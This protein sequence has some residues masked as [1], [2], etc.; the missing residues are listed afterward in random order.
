VAVLSIATERLS[1]EV[2]DPSAAPQV[3]DYLVRNRAFHRPWDPPRNPDHFT[4]AHW[5]QQLAV[6][7]KLLECRDAA[8]FFLF[9]GDRVVGHANLSVL[10]WG[11][12]CAANLGY[13]LC[14]SAQGKGL[15]GEALRALLPWAFAWGLH[16]V[17]ANYIPENIR[18]GAM[19]ARL[20][21]VIEGH[22]KDY[23]FIDGAWR[24]HVLTSLTAGSTRPATSS[25]TG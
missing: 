18:S 5:T 21:F 17:Q 1:V 4:E 9:D 14:E 10:A 24:D 8:R 6:N 23:L 2:P 12:F 20:G 19:L 15:M 16:R 7:I 3:A 25:P 13:A 11:P 22:A